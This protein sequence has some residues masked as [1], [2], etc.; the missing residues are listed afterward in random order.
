MWHLF[1][2]ATL[3]EFQALLTLRCPETP[4]SS[5]YAVPTV[6]LSQAGRCPCGAKRRTEL[7][8]SFPVSHPQPY[9]S[10]RAERGESHLCPTARSS[11]DTPTPPL[12]RGQDTQ[13]GL[14]GRH[15]L[16]Q[17][18]ALLAE[19]PR[20]GLGCALQKHWAHYNVFPQASCPRLL[21]SGR[22]PPRL[23][24]P[25]SISQVWLKDTVPGCL[26]LRSGQRTAVSWAP[27]RP[28]GVLGGQWTVTGGIR[29]LWGLLSQRTLVAVP[30]WTHSLLP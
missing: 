11:E 27:Q 24:T 22:S 19:D 18:R 15:I 4:P 6:T 5:P 3:W 23:Q 20:A 13:A 30:E 7:P 12:P 17:S 10:A 16:M 26:P 28:V 2:L 1:S 21:C 29:A 14:A 8:G 9:P 25:G